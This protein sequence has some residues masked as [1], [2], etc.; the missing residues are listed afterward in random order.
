MSELRVAIPEDRWQADARTGAGRVWSKM[1]TLL[2][3]RGIR[4]EPLDPTRAKPGRRRSRRRPDVWLVP[5][6]AGHLALAEPIVAIVHGAAWPIEEHF[7]DYTPRVYGERLIAT[8]AA[9][10]PSV[11][12]VIVPSQYTRRGLLT[13]YDIAAER[14]HVVPHGVDSRQFTS[15]RAADGRRLVEDRLGVARPYVLFASLPT[16]G[17]KNL[18]TL[19]KAMG[20]LAAR[21]L[22]HALAIAGGPAGGESP[23]ELAEVTADLPGSPGRVA[24]LDHL[25][26]HQLSAAMAGCAA[27]CLPS[28]FESFGLTALEAMASGAPVVVSDRGALPEVVGA[29]AIVAE[30]TVTGLEQALVRI[31]TQPQLAASLRRAGRARAEQMTWERTADGWRNALWSAAHP[32][33][34][35][36]TPRR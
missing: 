27:F 17:Q 12:R 30:P 34:A 20:R 18:R 32:G 31:I 13:G 6:D 8:M 23:E 29:A 5:G 2:P 25:G 14:V 7:F 11:S 24:W 10:L 33:Q 19:R 1:L 28:L 15:E 9:T 26:D 4:L 22:P 16:I 36:E 21:G 3:A 35:L